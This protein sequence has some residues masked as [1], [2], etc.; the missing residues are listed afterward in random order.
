MCLI[1][2]TVERFLCKNV[3]QKSQSRFPKHTKFT[4][5][6]KV[7]LRERKRHTYRG[8]SSTPSVV[9]Y[10]GGIPCGGVPH[11]KWG[12]TPGYSLSGPGRGTPHPRLDGGMP[13][14]RLDEGTHRG[15]TWLG[16]PPSDLAGVPP[17]WT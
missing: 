15:W 11:P 6:K 8:V 10:R 13:H 12:G 4:L 14:P 3:N 16:Y 17:I 7:L 2:S 1:S 9:L 5:S